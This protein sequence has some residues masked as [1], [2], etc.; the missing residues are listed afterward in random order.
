MTAAAVR[1]AGADG[2]GQAPETATRV[3]RARGL[4]EEVAFIQVD[5]TDVYTVLHRPLAD[6]VAGVLICCSVMSEFV[7]NYRREVLLARALASQGVAVQRFH[8]RGTGNSD[9][10]EAEAHLASMV[11]DAATVLE[12]F[13]RRTGLGRVVLLGTRWGGLVAAA[14]AAQRPGSPLVLW[15]PV[16]DGSRYFREMIRG[17]LVR[18]MKDERFAGA[19]TDAWRGELERLGRVD[20]L[21][22]PLHRRLY[23]SGRE[24]RLSDL[25]SGQTAPVLLVQLGKRDS[26]RPEYAAIRDA[27]SARGVRCEAAAV[28]GNPDWLFHQVS[29]DAHDLSIET[30]VRWLQGLHDSDDNGARHGPGDAADLS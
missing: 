5:G 22:Y 21:G 8:Y 30:T 18:E 26:L 4:V 28:F 14:P 29:A 7:A 24:A 17:R 23:E 9:G 20:I 6:P 19:G 10:G 12:G 13:Q 11:H 25:L 15:E 16:T 3:D 27:L 1:Q 2:D